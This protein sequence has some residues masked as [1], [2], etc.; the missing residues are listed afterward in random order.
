[1][2]KSS[3]LN[4]NAMNDDRDKNSRWSIILLVLFVV[5][6]NLEYV[7]GYHHVF[8]VLYVLLMIL[9]AWWLPVWS[10]YVVSSIAAALLIVHFYENT[11]DP[12]LMWGHFFD[13]VRRGLV[14]CVTV[15]LT[16]LLQKSRERERVIARIDPLTGLA[17]RLAFSERVEAEASRCQRFGKRLSIA[18]LD[19][20]D[21]KS[22]NDS[23]GHVAGDKLL[24][25]L[26]TAITS[27]IRKYDVV[28]RLGGD[29]FALL[30]AEADASAAKAIC[31]RVAEK[32]RESTEQQGWQLTV[33]IGIATFSQPE[34]PA[35][36]LLDIADQT[37]YEAKRE[38]PGRLYQKTIPATNSSDS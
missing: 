16:N 34:M 13:G 32:I 25:V 20:D 1:M 14:L 28:A 17:N 10:A 36:E 8:E 38:G 37:M 7:F 24:R 5:I 21:F 23:W 29:E 22:V 11:D 15:A 27:S 26:A 33:S 4:S 12:I 18:Y 31:E 30:I 9:W 6:A 2:Q 35:D 3:L 19:C